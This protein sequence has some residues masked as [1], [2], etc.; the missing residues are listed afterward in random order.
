MN[1]R[2]A[3]KPIKTERDYK[4]AL[5]F[6]D[7][8]FDAKARTDQANIVEVLAILVEKYEEEHFP[9]DSPDPVE[10]IKLVHDSPNRAPTKE[11]FRS[12]PG[13]AFS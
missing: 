9:I 8:F 2:F 10:A 4:K 3:L 5:E 7:A 6:I 1:S 11:P 13:R 12:C